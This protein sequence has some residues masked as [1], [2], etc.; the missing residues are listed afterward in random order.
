L[1]TI[2]GEHLSL[3]ELVNV[4][5]EF[6]PVQL[7]KAALER[8]QAA[9]ALVEETINSGKVAYGVNTGFGKFQDKIIDAG[10]A[11]KLQENLLM[12]HA[13]GV[14][15]NLPTEAVRAAMLLRANSL[16]RG[17][18]GIRPETLELL[19]SCLNARVHPVVPSQGSLGASGDLAP[20]AHMA[21]VL[22]GRGEAE[23]DGEV[24]PGGKALKLKNL[25]PVVLGAKEGLALINGVQV[26]TALMALAVVDT[27]QLIDAAT[28]VSSITL[29][30]LRGLTAAFDE[31]LSMARPH[32][33][34]AEVAR[35]M[36]GTLSGSRLVTATGELRV[37][38]AY[39]LR[40]IPQVHGA[41]LDAWRHVRDVVLVE[42]NSTT[43]N[44]L[45]FVGEG[46]VISG[47]NFHGEPL[48]LPADYLGIAVSE[49]A[50]ISERRVE[51][52]VN[53][54]LSGLPAFLTKEGGLNSG[55]MIAQY[56]AASL[57]SENKVLAHPASVD[58]IPSSAN[59]EDH[60]SMGT[61]A[62]RKLRQIVANASN[63]LGIEYLTAC[64]AVD[65]QSGADGLSPHTRR[66]YDV[67]RGEVPPVTSDREMY[68]DIRRAHA[69]VTGSR[70]L[71]LCLSADSP[72]RSALG[73]IYS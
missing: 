3:R 25:E 10:A 66:A 18:S 17:Y 63:V 24:M 2:D 38:D 68:P 4:A 47:G 30:A 1:V 9:R 58:S 45:L 31:R 42:M 69:A 34:Q 60:V 50:N 11:Q 8:V 15:E 62:A 36:R 73:E 35:A 64:Q 71:P 19:I 22:I 32:P 12:S 21:L 59:Q 20:L 65:I 51:R 54:A 53:P 27:A 44:P 39:A 37:Q 13:C 49:L 16:A 29:Q 23:V 67:L 5:R 46:D 52:L 14:G 56:T 57:V 40:C 48:A 26:M 28:I 61:I 43:D 55:F 70:F 7:S 41:V 6:E 72:A 33:G